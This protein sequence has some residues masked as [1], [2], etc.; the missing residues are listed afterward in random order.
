MSVEERD[1]PASC[2]PGPFRISPDVSWRD[3]P[4]EIILF[5]LRTDAYHVL[6]EAAAQI[7]RLLADGASVATAVA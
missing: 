5:D 4:A 2:P 3:A 6:N 7:W 1:D